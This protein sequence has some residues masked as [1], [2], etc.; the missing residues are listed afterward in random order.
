MAKKDTSDFREHL[1]NLNERTGKR[2]WIYPKI[3]S[4]RFYRY[5]SWFSAFLL[6]LLFVGPWLRWKGHPLFLFDVLERKF[7]IAGLPFFP[8]DFYLLALGLLSFIVF[9]MLFT[10][11]FGRL[12]CGWVCPQTVF[13]EMVFRRIENWIEGNAAAQKKLDEGPLN[14]EKVWK[15]TAKHT[16]FWLI[17]FLIA[18]TFLAY[19]IGS[20]ALMKIIT[21]PVSQHRAGFVSI[22]IFTSVFY[23]VFAK[24]RELVCIIICPYGRLQGVLLDQNSVVVAYDH[25]RGEPRGRLVKGQ[26]ESGKGDCVDCGLCVEVCPTGID[27][28]N[29]TQLECVACTA[30]MDACDSV[31][32]KIHK[33]LGL[34]RYASE[35]Q[36]VSK[37][38]FSYTN[39]MKAYTV[40]F[41]LLFGVFS[42]LLAL[43]KDLQ[44]S[45][46]RTPGTTF[47]REQDGKVAN[48]F[49][50]KLTNKTFH[51]MNVRVALEGIPA[52]IQMLD[53]HIR[54]KG[55]E[56]QSM[57]VI[58]HL[59]QADI[60]ENTTPF[61]VVVYADNKEM[62]R[63]KLFFNGPVFD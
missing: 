47:V 52:S 49:L 19:I 33:P 9:I 57:P 22:L 8:Q 48:F 21:E 24:L 4:G 10:S 29:G 41:V 12:W 17:S 14:A 26:T 25:Q 38:T 18:N 63:V 43:R 51:D 54:I 13:M 58:V 15:K 35:Q 44:A 55:G 45:V 37:K 39:R 6:A 27:I 40:F 28:R 32:E 20:D 11:I 42:T 53:D 62:N 46:L 59:K 7:I 34:I 2:T 3:I 1:S 16:L 31:M 23:L 5:R 36:I 56:H 30:C 50:L 60:K 61:Q